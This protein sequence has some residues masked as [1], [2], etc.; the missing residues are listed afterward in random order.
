MNKGRILSGMRPTGRLHLGNLVGALQN[1]VSL[2]DQY[3][4]FYMIADWHAIMSEYKDTSRLRQMTLETA[5]DWIACGLD[6]DRSTIFVQSHVPEHAELHL[7]L[8]MVTPLGWLERVPTYK[9]QLKELEAKEV[10]TYGF[11]G[12]PVLQA[13]DIAIYKATLVPVGEDQLA[14]LELTREIIRRFNHYYGNIFPEPQAKLTK[15]P[16]LLGTDGTRKMSK[17]YGNEIVLSEVSA[18]LRRKVGG[19]FTDPLRIK[20]TDPGRP[21][22]CNVHT[23]YQTFRPELRPTVAQEC[24]T[25]VRGCVDCKAQLAGELDQYVEPI[26]RKRQD[27]LGDP[28]LLESILAAGRDRARAIAQ[29]TLSEVRSAMFR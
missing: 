28:F 21:E 15:M 17:S 11:L 4:C 3:E 16:K 7:A 10:N 27:L 9:E 29:K 23:F 5:A 24:R 13:V 2:Q 14:H 1:W 18:E 19:M 22:V 20:R 6:P 12:Y 25:A 8:S 26:R